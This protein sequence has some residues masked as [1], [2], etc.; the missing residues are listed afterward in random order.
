MAG[1]GRQ[2]L[3]HTGSLGLPE[4]ILSGVKKLI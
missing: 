4:A 2:R 3:D 1:D